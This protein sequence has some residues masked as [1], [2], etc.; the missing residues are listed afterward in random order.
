VAAPVQ[1]GF[2]VG[3]DR[4]RCKDA[5]DSQRSMT[6]VLFADPP[7]VPL[8]LDTMTSFMKRRFMVSCRPA[9][10]YAFTIV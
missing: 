10:A 1:P 8:Y 2:A 5:T 9:Y 7:F 6:L 4:D 3:V